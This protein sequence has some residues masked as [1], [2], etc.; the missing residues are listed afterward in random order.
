MLQPGCLPTLG[1]AKQGPGWWEL[2]HS[3]GQL[4]FCFFCM[5]AYKTERYSQPC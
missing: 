3:D 5:V 2:Q 4:L 1:T